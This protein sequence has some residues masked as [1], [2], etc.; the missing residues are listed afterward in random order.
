MYLDMRVAM[1]LAT[2]RRRRRRIGRNKRLLSKENRKPVEEIRSLGEE[3]RQSCRLYFQ[4]TADC[5]S[6]TNS[7]LLS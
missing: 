1:K 7:Q 2:A 5:V 3:V 6:C 4:Y